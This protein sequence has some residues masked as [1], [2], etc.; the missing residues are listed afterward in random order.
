[1]AKKILGVVKLQLPAGKATPAPPVGPALG[2]YGINL[3]GFCKDFNARTQGK[4]GLIVPAVVTVYKDRS[5]TFILKSPPASVLL[6]RAA[7]LAKG[8]AESNRDKVGTVT[9]SQCREIAKLKEKDLNAA[10]EEAAISMIAGTA[11]S[12]GLEVVDG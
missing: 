5:F 11:R 1:M 10:S 9:V 7:G 4:E 3:A 2:Q 8:S 12:M 6:K